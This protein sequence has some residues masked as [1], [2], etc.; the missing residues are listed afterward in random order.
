MAKSNAAPKTVRTDSIELDAIDDHG[1]RQVVKLRARIVEP[2]GQV[3]QLRKEEQEQALEVPTSQADDETKYQRLLGRKVIAPPI[4][5]SKLLGTKDESTELG[6]AI[7]AMVTNTVGFGWQLKERT[8]PEA[9]R[10]RLAPQIEQERLM[11]DMRLKTV[12]PMESL[13]GLREKVANDKHSC[14][15]GYLELICSARGELVGS[16]HV[17]GHTIRLTVKDKVPTK[18]LVPRI[19]P[20]RDFMVE[21]VPMWYRFRRFGQVREDDSVI[22]FKEAGDPRTLHKRKGTFHKDPREVRFSNRATSLVHFKIYHAMTPYGMPLWVGNSLSVRGSRSAEEINWATINNNNIPSMMIIVE[23]G[24]LTDGSIDRLREWT[25][26]HIASSQNY[27]TFL[28]LEGEATEEGAPN[29]ANFR[30]RL[31]P[32]KA[33][34]QKDEMFQEYQKHNAERVRQAF[35]LPPIF[36]GRCHSADTEYLTLGGW[37][38]FDEIIGDEFLATFNVETGKLE[39]QQPVDRCK[40]DYDGELLHLK[41]RGVDALVTPNHGMWT[42]ATTAAVRQQ[43]PWGFVEAQDLGGI[44]GKLGGCIEIPTS[45][46]WD[47]EHK[48]TFVIPGGK[49]INSRDPTAPTE[50]RARDEARAVREAERSADREVSMNSFLR[51]LGYFVSEG[52]T[53]KTRGPIILSQRIGWVADDMIKCLTEL[54]FDPGVGESR[55]GE[56]NIYICHSGLWEWLRENCGVGSKNK[57]LPRWVLGLSGDQLAIVLAALIAGDGSFQSDGRDSS[58]SYTTTSKILNDQLH[59]ICLKCGCTLTTRE[60]QPE[61]QGWSLKYN[62][63]GAF[64]GRHLLQPL[65]QIEI[66]PYSGWVACFVVPNGTLV[67]RRNGRV[68]ISGNSDDYSRATADTSRDIADEQIFAP[69]RQRDDH[70]INR[71]FISEWGAR[72]HVFRSNHPN[73]TDDIELIRLMAIAEKSGAMTPRRADSIIR[74][75]FGDDIGPMPTGIDLDKPFAITFAEA[76]QGISSETSGEGTAKKV[77]ENLVDMR[78]KIEKELDARFHL[79]DGGDER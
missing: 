51:F 67:T 3:I 58:F 25:E 15:N 13:T 56:L 50:N 12:H 27:S 64:K 35:R 49:R 69:E 76:Q 43:K 4:N 61:E 32:L 44:K 62:S 75:V 70:L 18:M 79:E 28:I 46:D 10:A 24:R 30:I 31:E 55:D 66:V 23:N 16:E 72:F 8:I 73:I 37:K 71:F 33:V 54:G 26:K 78:Q 53:T 40:Y 29:P 11:L 74:D 42:R 48:E 57:R 22:W 77:I 6:Q 34:Q 38:K 19:R 52:S 65:V 21:E 41:N 2:R 59:E 7:D 20:D 63:Y 17:Q 47:G 9:L 14:G 5:L 60:Y 39:Y 1:N 68:L 36:V 45:A